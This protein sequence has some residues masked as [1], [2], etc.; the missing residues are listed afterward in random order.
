MCHDVTNNCDEADDCNQYVPSSNT[1]WYGANMPHCYDVNS[2]D[3]QYTT[4]AINDIVSDGAVSNTYSPYYST[5]R[6]H[7]SC[8][9]GEPNVCQN[10]STACVT[11]PYYAAQ[12]VANVEQNGT[13]MPGN[14]Y[15]QA[16]VNNMYVT[17][18]LPAYNTN[19]YQTETLYQ[20]T[21]HTHD[22]GAN[23]TCEVGPTISN[24]DQNST[25]MYYTNSNTDNYTHNNYY[26][27][28]NQQIHEPCQTV[29][30]GYYQHSSPQYQ[31][32]PQVPRHTNDGYQYGDY[33]YETIHGD[34]RTH[35]VL[36]GNEPVPYTYETY[37]GMQDNRYQAHEYDGAFYDE[38]SNTETCYRYSSCTYTDTTDDGNQCNVEYS[39]HQVIYTQNYTEWSYRG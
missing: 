8:A 37:S 10:N 15:A 23:Y 16:G 29:Q 21:Y 25:Q 13:Y 38:S 24:G 5:D 27:V 20:Q 36:G 34:T 32:Q 22:T 18:S 19:H 3:N 2:V 17:D 7:S 9:T 31:N 4:N 14:T 1:S 39:V 33:P 30:M 11:E 12:T 35:Q 6:Y 26:S 28:P